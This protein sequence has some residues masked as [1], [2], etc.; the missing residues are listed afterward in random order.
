MGLINIHAIPAGCFSICGAK[1][2][3]RNTGEIYLIYTLREEVGGAKAT[4]A[5]A[6]AEETMSSH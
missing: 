5:A 4:A 3:S 1:T 6:A 2:H